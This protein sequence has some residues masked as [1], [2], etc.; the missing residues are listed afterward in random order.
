MVTPT[1]NAWLL[2]ICPAESRGKF[3]GTRGS[4]GLA[5]TAAVTLGVGQMLDLFEASGLPL[6]GFAVLG[7]FWASAPLGKW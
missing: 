3:T 5:V 2:A 6:V 7:A 1:T 4:L